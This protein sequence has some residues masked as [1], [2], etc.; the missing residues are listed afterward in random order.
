MFLLRKLIGHVTIGTKS[1][2]YN[3]KSHTGKTEN[4]TKIFTQMA[5]KPKNRILFAKNC[6]FLLVSIWT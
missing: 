2:D 4:F 3:L 5:L 1:K 6:Y